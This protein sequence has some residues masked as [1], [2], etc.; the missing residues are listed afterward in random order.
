[1]PDGLKISNRTGKLFYDSDAW[2]AGVDY[3]NEAFEDSQD[4]DYEDQQ[5]S[6]DESNDE[7]L[8]ED[9]DEWLRMKYMKQNS[10]N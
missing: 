5:A 10:L 8:G 6:D 7:I 2:I 1:M 9:Y 4:E 3:D